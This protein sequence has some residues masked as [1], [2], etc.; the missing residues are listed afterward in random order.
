MNHSLFGG[1]LR[2][3]EKLLLFFHPFRVTSDQADQ[4]IILDI[5]SNRLE[6]ILHFFNDFSSLLE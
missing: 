2:L 5:V 6:D 4:L 1:V 3:D